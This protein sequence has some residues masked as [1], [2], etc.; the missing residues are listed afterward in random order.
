MLVLLVLWLLLNWKGGMLLWEVIVRLGCGGLWLMSRR[1]RMT[2]VGGT[3]V[4]SRGEFLRVATIECVDAIG[5]DLALEAGI[6]S[7]RQLVAI[8]IAR[9]ECRHWRRTLWARL[10]SNLGLLTSL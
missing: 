2:I 3:L 9:T 6:H 8:W 5:P 10:A 4:A 7:R 1:I